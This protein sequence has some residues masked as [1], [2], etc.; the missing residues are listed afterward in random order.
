M[1][2]QVVSWV[3]ERIKTYDLR[4]VGNPWKASNWW[5]VSSKP[6]KT[7]ILTVVLENCQKSALK[8][9]NWILFFLNFVNL[10]KIFFQICKT[11]YKSLRKKGL[12]FAWL[13]PWKLLW[14]LFACNWHAKLSANEIVFGY[15]K[16]YGKDRLIYSRLTDRNDEIKIILANFPS[17][18]SNCNAQNPALL[19]SFLVTDPSN[20]SAVAFPP[21]LNTDYVVSACIYL[22]F[23]RK[24]SFSSCSIWHF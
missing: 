15:S 3:P 2:V 21:L 4:K 20:Y 22:S 14:F 9:S 8:Q 23:T 5:Q 18:M 16:I 19:D 7:Q 10:S 1:N 11:V 6:P 12:P 24:C 17:W 13:F